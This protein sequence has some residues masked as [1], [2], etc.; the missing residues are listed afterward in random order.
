MFFT[1]SRPYKKNDQA[2]IESKNNH[3][4]RRYGFSHRYNTKLELELLNQLWALVNDPLNFFTPTK[5]PIGW[6]TNSAGRHKRL[7][8][9][10]RSPYHR[11]LTAGVLN[12]TQQAELATHKAGPRPTET[13]RRIHQIPS[14]LTRLAAGKTR[15]LQDQA[16]RKAPNPTGPKTRSA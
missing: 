7:Y 2:T 16:A 3:L 10:P 13:A 6:S 15:R 9:K 1:R 14:E 11:L 12:P 4:V 8:N 5:K